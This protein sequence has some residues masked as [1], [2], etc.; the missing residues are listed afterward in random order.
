MVGCVY[1]ILAKVLAD[2]LRQV[3]HSIV[4]EPQV[5]FVSGKQ[6]LDGVLIANEIIDYWKKG[7]S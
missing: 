5:A 3:L 6:I 7:K 4:G 1:K 2:K